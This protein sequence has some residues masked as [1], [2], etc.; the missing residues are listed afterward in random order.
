[1]KNAP[2][3]LVGLAL[4]AGLLALSGSA[5]NARAPQADLDQR[6]E[7]L[8]NELVA[9]RAELVGLKQE[10]EAASARME[11]VAKWADAQAKAADGLAK[12]LDEAERQGFTAGINFESRVTLLAGWRK[13]L[14]EAQKGLEEKPAAAPAKP[15]RR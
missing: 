6:V 8:E 9:A 10:V 15:T 7:A 5:Q 2:Q 1:M 13:A 3:L 4:A 12:A 14:G 11:R